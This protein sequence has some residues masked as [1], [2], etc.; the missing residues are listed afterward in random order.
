M[1]HID[2]NTLIQESMI[3]NMKDSSVIEESIDV[4]SINSKLSAALEGTSSDI[5]DMTIADAATKVG[6]HIESRLKEGERAAKD[7]SSNLDKDI[8][9]TKTIADRNISDAATSIKRKVRDVGNTI[10]DKISPSF[11]NK[12]KRVGNSIGDA[13]VDAKTA[14]TRAAY[15]HPYVAGAG[16][17]GAGLMAKRAMAKRSN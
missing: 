10:E 1:A 15:D 12:I 13:L 9:K 6:K 7:F 11:G 2:I 17:L 3:S 5:G 4:T 8:A 16:L 14:V